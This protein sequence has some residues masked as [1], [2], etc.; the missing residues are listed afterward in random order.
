MNHPALATSD[1]PIPAP[2]PTAPSE[3]HEE[4]ALDEALKESFS[5]GAPIA[6]DVRPTPISIAAA[7]QRA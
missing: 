7:D 3:Q 2:P 6:V 4:Q 1:Q 5:A